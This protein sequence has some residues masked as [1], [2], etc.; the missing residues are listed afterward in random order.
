VVESGAPEELARREGGTF[1]RLMS[2]GQDLP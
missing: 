2:A 1:R